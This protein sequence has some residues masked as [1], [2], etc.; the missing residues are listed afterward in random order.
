MGLEDL[1]WGRWGSRDKVVWLQYPSLQPHLS[2]DVVGPLGG[3]VGDL[4]RDHH[5]LGSSR[6]DMGSWARAGRGCTL[7]SG[8]CTARGLGP[9]RVEVLSGGRKAVGTGQGRKWTAKW[10]FHYVSSLE[11]S[12]RG[13]GT[14]DQH[15]QDS[16]DQLMV[17]WP[18]ELTCALQT[19]VH[20]LHSVYLLPPCHAYSCHLLH[21]I[22]QQRLP[23]TQ[24][25]HA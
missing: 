13:F 19:Q 23:N 10:P 3:W 9:A 20:T 18:P 5:Y 7:H 24:M 14:W 11:R 1:G 6:V 15:C 12:T 21:A 22:L 25:H 8:G 2:R 4:G 17:K 16:L